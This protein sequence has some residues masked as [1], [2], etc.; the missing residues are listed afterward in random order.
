[1]PKPDYAA[2]KRKLYR[3]I[4]LI[5][6]VAIV[7]VA[8]LF[9]VASFNNAGDFVVYILQRYFGMSSYNARWTYWSVLRP[10]AGYVLVAAVA[11][12]FIIL[13]R[14]LLSQFT[15]CFHEISDG[16]DVLVEDSD[17]EI[18]LSPEMASMESKL[19]IIKLTLDKREQEARL[20]E[21]R[22]NDMV[23]YL[24]HDIKTPLT[25]VVGYLSLL[26][27]A[28][29]MPVEQKAKYVHITLEKANRLERLIDE[30]FEI[31]RYNFQHVALSK[32]TIDL[33]YML[34]QMTEEF[35]PLL[36]ARGMRATLHVPED[37][38]LSG[39]PDKLARVF[40]NILRN[41]VAY[42]ADDG[43]IDITATCLEGMVSI[44]FE[45]PGSIPKDKLASIF[46]KFYR[47]DSARST[48]T[49]GAGLGLAIAKEIVVEHGGRIYADSG[50]GVTTF[51]VELPV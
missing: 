49:G 6:L 8:L 9:L 48:D 46:D 35:Y 33:Y 19:R 38:T 23:M 22:K 3:K 14:V 15:K 51:T 7:F 28:P 32:E 39:D 29:D 34:A 5:T 27:E 47:L 12:F 44:V 42:S 11:V 26:D 13:S 25:S 18:V 36:S 2:F 37:L 16:L 10:N 30:F 43:L 21:Q 1:V 50:E 20:A 4:I 17:R 31:T 41:A 24:A 45:N 40:H